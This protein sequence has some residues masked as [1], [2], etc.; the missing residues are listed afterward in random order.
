LMELPRKELLRIDEVADY[1]SVTVRTVYL[2]IEHGHLKTRKT[3]GG[4]PRVLRSSI[5]KCRIA[6]K[7]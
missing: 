3:P 1:F 4:L 5:K 2:W 7:V 6:K